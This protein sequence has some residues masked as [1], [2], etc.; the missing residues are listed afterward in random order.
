MK[1]AVPKA[2]FVQMGNIYGDTLFF[3]AA[4]HGKAGVGEPLRLRMGQYCGKSQIIGMIPNQAYG[5][6]AKL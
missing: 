4:E 3:H 6:H 1:N 5:P 2:F